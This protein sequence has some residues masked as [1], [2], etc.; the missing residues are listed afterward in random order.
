MKRLSKAGAQLTNALL[1]KA[2][3]KH[4]HSDVQIEIASML[5][6]KIVIMSLKAAVP[7]LIITVP[8]HG[9]IDIAEHLIENV[10][11]FNIDGKGGEPETTP[12]LAAI[13]RG[14]V[15]TEARLI[16]AQLIEAGANV[17]KTGGQP[18]ITPLLAAVRHNYKEIAE[19]L[20]EK[21]AKLNKSSGEPKTR[22]LVEAIKL[23]HLEIAE[24]LI[25]KGAELDKR[26]VANLK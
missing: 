6:K 2:I 20:I 3:E 26:E 11:G 16:A 19:L 9:Q 24:L 23:G 7:N 14:Q 21:G 13:N 8:H 4:C 10:D 1:K 5:I 15:D 12:L 22:P 25:E 17:N 18:K